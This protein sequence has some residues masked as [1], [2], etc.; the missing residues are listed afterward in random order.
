MTVL[1]RKGSILLK[2]FP[3]GSCTFPACPWGHK[4]GGGL[5]KKWRFSVESQLR[6]AE[7]SRGPGIGLS[8]RVVFGW[9]A[10]LW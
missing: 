7:L 6:E 4:N 2:A 1:P 9:R 8:L 10:L 3:S 5:L